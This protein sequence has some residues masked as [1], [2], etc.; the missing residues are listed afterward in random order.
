MKLLRQVLWLTL[1]HINTYN[2]HSPNPAQ[3]NRSHCAIQIQMRTKTNEKRKNPNRYKTR[4]ELYIIKTRTKQKQQQ[5][6]K[7]AR[8]FQLLPHTH[9]P[10]NTN[11]LK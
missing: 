1:K 6:R 3:P 8:K 7:K 9:Q 10:I 11:M 2:S 5:Q 4:T